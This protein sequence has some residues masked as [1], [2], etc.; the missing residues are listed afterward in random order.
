ME[1]GTFYSSVVRHAAR[2]TI[3][4]FRN[5]LM[6]AVVLTVIGA[7]TGY[8]LNGLSGISTSSIIWQVSSTLLGVVA[9]VFLV[10]TWNLV[11]APVYMITEKD[12]LAGQLHEEMRE[13]TRR[14]K[15][16][17]DASPR[18][19]LTDIQVALLNQ[20]DRQFE[21]LELWYRNE[22]E[23]PAEDSIA[24]DVTADVEILGVQYYVGF[25]ADW[26]IT[27]AETHAGFS[28]V[29][30]AT[31]IL[32]NAVTEKLAICI[33]HVGEP[34]AYAFCRD[35][36]HAHADG[37]HPSYRIPPGEYRLTVKMRGIRLP[38]TTRH[39]RLMTTNLST[40]TGIQTA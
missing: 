31:D 4:L 29:K 37:R 26:L 25:R 36:V 23:V 34:D 6:T 13:A 10:V 12:A 2:N 32:P 38:E 5:R 8:L 9:V 14:L 40:L 7:A 22:P 27:A 15:T 33:R 19:T 11:M 16:I 3:T 17:D 35:N 30:S 24:R 18:V 20:D 1:P 21:I 39:M 28:G